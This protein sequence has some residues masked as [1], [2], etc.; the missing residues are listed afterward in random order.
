[1][2]ICREPGMPHRTTVREWARAWPEFGEGLLAAMR[3]ARLRRRCADVARAA[4]PRDPRGR[5]S[6]YTPELGAEICR[7]LTEG[8]TLIAIARDPEMPCYS[9]V[10]NWAKS[11]PAF[12]DAYAQ[13]RA[14]AGDY[15]FDEAREV[16][17]A[18]TPGSVWA[19]RLRFDVIR[20]QTAR[21][22]PRKYLER[23]VVKADGAGGKGGEQKPLK[24]LVT[25]FERGPNGK[26][27]A[28]PPR[29]AA[30]ERA[31]EEAYG[32]PYDGVR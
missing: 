13:A 18:A 31:Y 32:R 16:A 21:L 29:N 20:W 26:V 1:M 8:E 10:L 6:T 25:E 12:G 27:L 14:L 7:R 4:R 3:L 17:R 5:W 19:D 15:L 9:T 11:V 23:L 24:I 30:D 28:I 22:A 2:A